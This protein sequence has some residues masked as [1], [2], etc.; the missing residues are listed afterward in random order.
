MSM[1]GVIKMAR[2]RRSFNDE[3]NSESSAGRGSND[4]PDTR[5]GIVCNSPS[6]RVRKQPNQISDTVAILDLGDEVTIIEKMPEGYYKVLLPSN[7]IAYL[8]WDFCK[9]VQQ[10]E[11]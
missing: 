3:N 9:E 8:G 2:R 6:V 5:K 7:R 11:Q 10:D 1:E 4:A